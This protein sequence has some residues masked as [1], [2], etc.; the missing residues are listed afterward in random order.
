MCLELVELTLVYII[1]DHDAI[2][3]FGVFVIVMCMAWPSPFQLA[4]QGFIQYYVVAYADSTV[5]E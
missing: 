1:W 3:V 2:L 5:S 4:L